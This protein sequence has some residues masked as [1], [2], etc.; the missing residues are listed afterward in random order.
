MS[1][2]LHKRPIVLTIAGFDPSSGAGLSTDLK[3]F[4]QLKCYGLAV[5]T[6]NTI[7]TDNE[8]ISCHWTNKEIILS[9]LKTLLSRFQVDFVKIGIIENWLILAECIDVLMNHNPKIKIILDP[10]L[11]AS[12]NFKFHESDSTELEK[13]LNKIHLITPNYQEIELLYPSKTLEETTQHITQFTNLFLKGG[14]R[15]DKKGQDILFSKERKQY[16]MNPKLQNC[17]EKH[18]S[19]CVLSAAITAHLALGFP[20]MKACYRAKRYTEKFLSS[21]PTLLGFHK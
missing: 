17:S 12:T 20:L 13:I 14:H 18:G 9:Q 21:N 7:Q 8:F 1:N 4:E 19:G 3:S 15:Q 16:P 6:A 10:V 5:Q 11:N 2:P